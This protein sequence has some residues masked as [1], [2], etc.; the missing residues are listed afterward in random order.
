MK[1]DGNCL[2]YAIEDQLKNRSLDV[3]HNV[4][5]LRRLTAEY[6]LKHSDEFL[7]FLTNHDTGGCYSHGKYYHKFLIAQ[8]S[9]TP[10][11][12]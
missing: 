8:H 10:L 4:N 1:S 11:L 5:D 7:P 3:S 12:R 9:H 2:Y 6:M